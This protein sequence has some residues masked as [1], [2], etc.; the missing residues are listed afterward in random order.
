MLTMN[1]DCLTSVQA[2][3]RL[4]TLWEERGEE[5]ANANA[6]VSLESK[7]ASSFGWKSILLLTCVI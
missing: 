4:S 7:H 6:R 3:N 2:L 1:F 5:Y